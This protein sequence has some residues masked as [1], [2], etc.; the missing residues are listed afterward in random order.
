M[1]TSSLISSSASS[2]HVAAALFLMTSAARSATAPFNSWGVSL[3]VGLWAS[4][5][6]S[7]ALP[8]PLG[9]HQ[10]CLTMLLLWAQH[11]NMAGWVW[12]SHWSSRDHS[13]RRRREICPGGDGAEFRAPIWVGVEPKGWPKSHPSQWP[14]NTTWREY[15]ASPALDRTAS[16]P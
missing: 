6:W 4:V 8:P 3:Y 12:S 7:L 11:P 2:H 5:A 16:T 10:V 15:G 14:H 9:P 1:P 13:A